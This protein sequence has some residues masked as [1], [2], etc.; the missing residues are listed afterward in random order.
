[1]CSVR[2]SRSEEPQAVSNGYLDPETDEVLDCIAISESYSPEALVGCT[3]TV[4]SLYGKSL[5]REDGTF[6]LE[7]GKTCI[8][9]GFFSDSELKAGSNTSR[10]KTETL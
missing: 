10:M 6:V 8:V 4:F 5:C 7:E 2:S 1:M 9:R 3:L